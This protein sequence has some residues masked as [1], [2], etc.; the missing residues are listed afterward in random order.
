P[1]R[2]ASLR[3]DLFDEAVQL[4]SLEGLLDVSLGAH[5]QAADGVLFLALGRDDDDGYRLV[6]GLLLQALQ[7]LEPVHD[8]HVDVEEDAVDPLFLVERVQ[9]LEPVHG[10]APLAVLVAGEEELVHLV[11]QC[12]IVPRQ[13]LPQH[14]ASPPAPAA[15]R[16]YRTA[17]RPRGP[18]TPAP[19]VLAP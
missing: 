5:L 19:S 12:R 7:K 14:R 16:A 13:D 9:A 11:G 1:D 15:I 6:G 2:E 17:T 3:G 10:A 4:R 18:G 8:G